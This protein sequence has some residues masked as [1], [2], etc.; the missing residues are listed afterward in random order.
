MMAMAKSGAKAGS[1]NAFG[2][3]AHAEKY[4][5]AVAC[6]V[7]GDD[8]FLKSEVLTAVRRQVLAGEEGDFGLTTFSGREVRLRDIHDALA[9]VSLFGAGRRLV[10]VE[11]ADS[12]VSECRAELE[13]HV[14][15]SSRGVLVLDVKSWPSNTR[16]A[17]EVA[18]AGLTIDCRSI[19]LM[20]PQE[21]RARE[22]ELKK[23]L[24]DRAKA[25]HGVRLESAAADALVEL[26]PP[27][28]GILIQEV[29]RLTLLAGE[30]RMI[31][32]KCVR[33]NVGGW[34]TRATWDMV[35]AAADG[36]TADAL[37]QLDRL[38]ASGEKPHGL[39][40]QLASTLRRFG[41][42]IELI[43]TAEA[44]GQRMPARDALSQ[45]GVPPF[46]LADAERQLRQ[47]GRRRA[48]SMAS[49]LL[50]ADLAMKGHNSSDD[51]ARIELERLIVQLGAVN[52]ASNVKS[53][54]AAR[55]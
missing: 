21:R 55:R 9:T 48:R 27:E 29:A 16:L 49:W 53:V 11:E 51:R 10:I 19:E 17:K 31:D 18:A 38:I 24:V 7:Y 4:P 28:P 3:L 41:T 30:D 13:K 26:I 37:S 54:S 50:A 40:P 6:A 34:R 22:R 14:A 45:A 42:A 47:V 5:L 25:V 43:E 33:E 23:W 8:V 2:Y 52:T 39:L 20:K 15:S 35:D 44:D 36:R 12:F 1:V 46:K 32:V